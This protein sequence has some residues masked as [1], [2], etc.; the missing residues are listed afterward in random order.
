MFEIR[1]GA[2]HRVVTIQ[3]RFFDEYAGI[4]TIDY[5]RHT[6][7]I[8]SIGRRKHCYSS[9][10]AANV[11]YGIST[12]RTIRRK[13]HLSATGSEMAKMARE[14]FPLIP[15]LNVVCVVM[16]QDANECWSELLKMLQQKLKPLQKGELVPTYK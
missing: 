9:T 16:F 7:R 15:L 10:V 2:M 3:R 8:Q 14:L 12:I 4:A 11:A 1:S 5:G 6:I 13:G